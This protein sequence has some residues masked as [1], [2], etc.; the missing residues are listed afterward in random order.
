MGTASGGYGGS[1]TNTSGIITGG[2]GG[3]AIVNNAVTG[4]TSGGLNLTQNAS[5]GNGGNGDNAAAGRG[6]RRGQHAQFF[7]QRDR[8]VADHLRPGWGRWKSLFNH[9]RRANQPDR[10]PVAALRRPTLP[11]AIAVVGPSPSVPSR[12]VEQA[13]PTSPAA[14]PTVASAARRPLAGTAK[15]PARD[16]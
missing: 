13:A 6:G 11:T 3:S 5:G 10:P 16:R 8:S 1:G 14:P 7:H 4:T 9:Y 15:A 12:S 2:R